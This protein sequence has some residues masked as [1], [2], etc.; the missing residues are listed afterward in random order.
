MFGRKR[1]LELEH[2][3]ES[4]QMTRYNHYKD[5]AKDYYDTF[6]KRL[7]ELK[8]TGKINEK[9]YHYYEHEGNKWQA[10]MKN[11]NH[12]NNVTGF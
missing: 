9:T 5:A 6:W 1:I 11:Y 3:L 8:E 10:K 12:Q 2:L 7:A 4:V